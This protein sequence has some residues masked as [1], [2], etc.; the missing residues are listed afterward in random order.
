L[1]ELTHRWL[2]EKIGRRFE[3]HD[4]DALLLDP[5]AD[6]MPSDGEVETA[7]RAVAGRVD[8]VLEWWDDFDI[9]LM[10]ALRQPARLLGNSDWDAV[11]IL[12]ME[13]THI[14][15]PSLV[16]PIG[17]TE[18]RLRLAAQLT[19][20]IGAVGDYSLWLV[21]SGPM[22]PRPIAGHPSRSTR[23][24]APSLAAS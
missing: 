20:R 13:F 4:L 16:L 12:P 24:V 7:V 19:G 18:G 10:P 2:E 21:S 14:G 17:M 23:S 5:R 11:G 9:M 15:F 6:V 1:T 8:G 22:R 3:Q